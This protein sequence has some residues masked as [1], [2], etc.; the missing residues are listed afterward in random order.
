MHILD[1]RIEPQ[2]A[3]GRVPVR[4]VTD[5]EGAPAAKPLGHRR[6]ESPMA[7]MEHFNR[8]IVLQEG[9]DP[10][11]HILLVVALGIVLRIAP[12]DAPL[13]RTPVPILG[14]KRQ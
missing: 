5:Q 6:L 13:L 8:R 11:G 2:S 10:Y 1:A 7:D 12:A 3:E 9:L 4:R 14:A